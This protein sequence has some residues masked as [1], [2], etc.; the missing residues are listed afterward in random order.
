MLTLSTLTFAFPGR[1]DVLSGISLSIGDGSHV[2]VMGPNGSGKSTLALMLKGILAPTAGTVSVDGFSAAAGER[3]RDE[4]MRRV[5]IVFQN[6]D[7]AIVSTTV[8]R[9]IAFGLENLGIPGGE[10]RAR[11]EETLQRFDLERYRFTSPEHLSGGEKQR[12][13]LAAV[14]VMRPAHLILD[15]PTSLLDPEGGERILSLIHET[16]QAGT[17][18]IHITQSATEALAAD[19]LIV[20]DGGAPILDGPPREVLRDTARYGIES[21]DDIHDPAGGFSA[22]PVPG[23]PATQEAPLVSL[24]GITFIYDAGTPF[25]HRALDGVS[26]DIHAG[27]AV[28]LLGPSGSGKT[29]LLEIA[30]GLTEPADGTVALRD[31]PLRAMAFQFPEDEV[32]GDTV[33]EYVAFGPGNIGFPP[34]VITRTVDDAL[35]AVGLDPARF[36]ARD[37]FTLSGGEK[38]RAAIAGVLAMNPRVLVLDEPTAGLDRRSAGRIA[39]ILETYVRNGGALLFST[40]DFRMARRLAHQTAVLCRG[41]IETYGETAAVFADSPWLGMLRTRTTSRL[42]P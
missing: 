33:A 37:P 21:L 6:P 34:G 42:N 10:M 15:E 23:S 27:K 2:A 19:R 22:A 36:R 14:M 18:V 35:M 4:V 39:D 9:E 26:L 12:L 41:R 5:G 29:T 31:T 38:R 16:A 7:N 11:V 24:R 30:A 1:P 3:E 13:A 20:L 40:H 17:T 8:E 32:F 28:T 25:A